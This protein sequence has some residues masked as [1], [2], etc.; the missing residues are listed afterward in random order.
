[1]QPTEILQEDRYL[2][3]QATDKV[4]YL[5]LKISESEAALRQKTDQALQRDK[6]YEI[7]L[8]N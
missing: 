4:D 7:I 1:M 3:M 6:A 2:E 5:R 8:D